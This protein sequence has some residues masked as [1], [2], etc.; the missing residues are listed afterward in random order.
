MSGEDEVVLPQGGDAV[1]GFNNEEAAKAKSP[2]KQSPREISPREKSN[3]DE[4]PRGNDRNSPRRVAFEEDNKVTYTPDN[5]EKK[6]AV[7]KWKVERQKLLNS[8][9]YAFAKCC[10]R[11]APLYMLIM[12]AIIPMIAIGPLYLADKLE[13]TMK[14]TSRRT[15]NQTSTQVKITMQ[16]LL[17]L[18]N[19]PQCA[20]KNSRMGWRPISIVVE[21]YAMNAQMD[22]SE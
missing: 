10:V 7:A 2:R 16:L 13:F 5:A 21:A 12:I 18:G 1:A 19:L 9:K 17:L 6:N 22:P 8:R 15:S 14:L 3:L 20:I 4:S 11:F